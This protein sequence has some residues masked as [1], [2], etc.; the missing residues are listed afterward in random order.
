MD[1]NREPPLL[2]SP[3]TYLIKKFPFSNHTR[4]GQKNK[5]IRHINFDDWT[6][7]DTEEV[8]HGEPKG[9]PREKYTYVDEM[10]S[11]IN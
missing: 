4:I 5:N 8:K 1:L 10:L 9:K 11:V 3:L 7:I 2:P 6:K